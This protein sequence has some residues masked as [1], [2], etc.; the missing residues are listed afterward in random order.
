MMDASV[1]TLIAM[2]ITIQVATGL[3][4]VAALATILLNGFGALTP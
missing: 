4:I 2:A 3:T 1:R